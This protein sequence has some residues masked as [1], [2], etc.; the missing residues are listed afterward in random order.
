MTGVE[1]CVAHS[2]HRIQYK[3]VIGGDPTAETL[4][5]HENG[6]SVTIPTEGIEPS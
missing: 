4:T 2:F 3:C 1:F 5:Y 6:G